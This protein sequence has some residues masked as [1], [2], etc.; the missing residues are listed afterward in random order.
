MTDQ[1]NLI[2]RGVPQGADR[3]Q[4][5]GHIRTVVSHRPTCVVTQAKHSESIGFE[6]GSQ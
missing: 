2:D 1:D 5:V 6:S 4:E 3:F